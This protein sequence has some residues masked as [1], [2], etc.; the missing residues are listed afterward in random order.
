MYS[1]RMSMHTVFV[2]VI[3]FSQKLIN[4]H[5]FFYQDVNVTMTSKYHGENFTCIITIQTTPPY[6]TST[7]QTLNIQ[8]KFS[9]DS[10]GWI[11]GILGAL[12]EL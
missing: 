5:D 8:C 3:S 11:H 9:K 12:S 10:L 4:L 7:S 6:E 1:V 2:D